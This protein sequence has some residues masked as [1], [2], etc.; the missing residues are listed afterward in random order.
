MV[1]SQSLPRRRGGSFPTVAREEEWELPNYCSGGGVGGAWEAA[2]MFGPGCLV[3]LSLVVS[4]VVS[5]WPRACQ[6]RSNTGVPA[7]PPNR[8]L[9]LVDF[10]CVL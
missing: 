7:G 2:K 9:S 1:A 4:G 10:R 6:E 5:G 8:I 3:F